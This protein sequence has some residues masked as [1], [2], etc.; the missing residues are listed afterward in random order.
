[1]QTLILSQVRE[2]GFN[3]KVLYETPTRIVVRYSGQK[4][5]RDDWRILK[6]G[7]GGKYI[8]EVK[9]TRRECLGTILSVAELDRT[10]I[11]RRQF[12]LVIEKYADPIV[13][14]TKTEVLVQLGLR[15]NDINTGIALAVKTDST[16]SPPLT[17]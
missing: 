17:V 2:S 3:D 1:M 6:H 16:G 10:P 4:S 15:V 9:P 7:V 5:G 11:G 14:R 12:C 8:R 13:A